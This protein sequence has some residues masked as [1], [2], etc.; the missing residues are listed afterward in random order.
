[1]LKN[2]I[3]YSPVIIFGILVLLLQTGRVRFGH[4]FGDIVDYAFVYL[5]LIL[6][7]FLLIGNENVPPKIFQFLSS[8]LIG[9]GIY[10]F[11]SMTIWRGGESSW[12]GKILVQSKEN[13]YSPDH[14]CETT[15]S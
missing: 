12:N 4:G 7:V 6:S 2:G 15:K 1:M 11:L 5:G 9:F 3:K 10:L 8:L 14:R 13:L